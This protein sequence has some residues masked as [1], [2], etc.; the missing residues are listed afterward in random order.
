M[1]EEQV[2]SLEVPAQP[3][4]SPSEP[5]T[6]EEGSPQ[7]AQQAIAAVHES[8]IVATEGETGIA[9]APL[10]EET[11]LPSE[12]SAPAEESTTEPLPPDGAAIQ[13]EPAQIM[14]TGEAPES[15]PEQTKS[16]TEQIE[17]S[18]VGPSPAKPKRERT[19]RRAAVAAQ[20]SAEERPAGNTATETP[21][22]QTP[23]SPPEA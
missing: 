11:S 20:A 19:A 17:G 10:A 22:S 5:V 6:V 8:Q 14:P 1:T 2:S 13:E 21:K 12:P 4:E 18:A 3:A 16:A 7:A 15:R 23:S 9:Q